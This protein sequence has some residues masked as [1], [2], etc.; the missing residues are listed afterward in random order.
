SGL[1]LTIAKHIV[2]KHGGSIN[3]DSTKK[4]T[5]FCISLPKCSV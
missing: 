5:H 2:E 1:G 3:L 4:K